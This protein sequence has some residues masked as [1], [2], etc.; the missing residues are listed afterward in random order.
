[1]ATKKTAR[2]VV[3]AAATAAS[4]LDQLHDLEA[5]KFCCDRNGTFRSRNVSN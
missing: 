3:D 5:L 2:G 1:M 4:R